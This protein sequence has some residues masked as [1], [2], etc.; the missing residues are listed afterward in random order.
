M[1]IDDRLL[2]GVI[3]AGSTAGLGPG[4]NRVATTGL[5]FFRLCRAAR[6]PLRG[7]LTRALGDPTVDDQIALV[8]EVRL[9]SFVSLVSLADLAPTMATLSTRHRLNVLGLEALAA[10]LHLGVGIHVAASNV[11][12]KLRAAA[13]AEGVPY[14]VIANP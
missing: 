11:G 8:R 6:A 10:A 12:P 4:A 14:V 2:A 3:R 7:T 1:L 9:P 13:A 5:W